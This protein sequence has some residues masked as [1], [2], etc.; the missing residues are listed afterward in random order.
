MWLSLYDKAVEGGRGLAV[1]NPSQLAEMLVKE[2]KSQKRTVEIVDSDGLA[3]YMNANPEGIYIITQGNTPG[4][5]F[6]KE[7]KRIL[8]IPALR[9]GGLVGLSVISPSTITGIKGQG[10]QV[11]VKQ[12]YLE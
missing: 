2:L 3:K 9:E 4:S 7:G 12:V 5:I 10:S 6:K 1:N 8:S 11:R